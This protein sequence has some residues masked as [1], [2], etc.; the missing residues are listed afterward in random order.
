M[1]PHPSFTCP[2]STAPHPSFTCPL[3]TAPHPSFTCPLYTAPHPSFTSPLST[4]PYP[5]GC[6][7]HSSLH[8]THPSRALHP[9]TP[10]ILH[11]PFVHSTPP[12]LH[13]PFVH[14]TLPILHVPFILASHPSFT[15]PSSTHPTHPS[16]AL[17]P[18]HPT[19]PAGILG[20]WREIQHFPEGLAIQHFWKLIICA[21]GVFPLQR[22]RNRVG[23]GSYGLPTFLRMIF[24]IAHALGK[25][26]S[27]SH[28]LGLTKFT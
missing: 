9:R 7:C 28:S 13:K 2:L 15:C 4:A 11:V 12:I 20:E 25:G 24:Y 23:R 21:P 1:A 5:S 19:H 10:P 3:S 17:C 18:Q 8:P 22:R 16:R 6:T 26:S 14:G 27:P